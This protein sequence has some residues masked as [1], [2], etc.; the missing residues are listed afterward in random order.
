MSDD[1]RGPGQ[2]MYP[3]NTAEAAAVMDPDADYYPSEESDLPL[4][5]VVGVPLKNG[6]LPA[7]VIP[8]LNRSHL[9]DLSGEYQDVTEKDVPGG[10]AG[11]D[12]NGKVSPYVIP[13]IVRGVQGERGPQG[14]QGMRGPAGERG[15]EGVAG[16]PG[17]R[18]QQG[19]RGPQGAQGPRGTSPDLSEYV[20][21]L[22]QP[23]LLSLGS[24]TLA[25]DLAYLLAELG[26]VRLA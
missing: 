3:H 2:R 25:R 17:P 6:L 16:P 24:E 23:P 19:E 10:Y 11:L 4:E 26:L 7:E 12:A 8:P 22:P 18:G 9:P 1:P 15:P 21:R 13:A 14:P 20:K 5:P